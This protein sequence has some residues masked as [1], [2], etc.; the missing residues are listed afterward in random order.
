MGT[1]M[2]SSVV[3]SPTVFTGAGKTRQNLTEDEKKKGVQSTLKS[4][5]REGSKT[6]ESWFM[7]ERRIISKTLLLNTDTL[8][9]I[10]VQNRAWNDT[11]GSDV[12]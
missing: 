6:P 10:T 2:H 9:L 4:C 11:I 3:P 8:D 7:M 12:D 5:K 1:A